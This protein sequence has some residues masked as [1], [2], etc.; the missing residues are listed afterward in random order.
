MLVF[1]REGKTGISGEKPLGTEKRTNNKLN[2]HT[3]PGIKPGKHW[4]EASSFTT[5]QSLLP[6]QGIEKQ[7]RTLTHFE[8]LVVHRILEGVH[9]KQTA[10]RNAYCMYMYND[11]MQ[12]VEHFEA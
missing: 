2:P 9:P 6:M 5:A 7:Y 3:G 8:Q 1:L 11:T 10:Q 12:P 4:W